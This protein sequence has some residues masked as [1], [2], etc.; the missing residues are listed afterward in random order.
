MA[1]FIHILYDRIIST[2]I[3]VVGAVMLICIL[4]QILT[5]TFF[6]MPFPWTDELAR[7]T[8]LWFCFI[9]S[10]MTLRKKMHLGI[11]YFESKMSPKA[12]FI[13]RICVYVLIILFGI[14][15]TVLGWQLLGI[16]SIQQ[17]PIIR[18]PMVL[19]YV[20]LPIAGFLYAILG[21]YQL[22]NHLTGKDE[23]PSSQS[24]VP[25]DV[26]EKG[27]LALKGGSK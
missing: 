7:F 9:G 17:S 26:M 25:V 13:N 24:D 27:A 19:I 11:D 20:S 5:R 23:D 18:L 16:V 2:I 21:M 8:F 22:I 6:Q 1:K 4:L 14:F 10:V 12:R 3:W 15:V